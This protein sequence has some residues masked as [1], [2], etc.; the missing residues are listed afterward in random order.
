MLD[1]TA[2]DMLDLSY[3]RVSGNMNLGLV[4]LSADNHVFFQA[5]LV[6]SE[7]LSARFILPEE[8]Q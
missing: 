8:G 7:S 5:S 3:T 2:G 4:V 6:T 1:A